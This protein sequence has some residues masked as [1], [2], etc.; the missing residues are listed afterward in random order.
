MEWPP[1]SGRSK[2]F[3][4]IDRAEWFAIETAKLKIVKGQIPILENL[5][6]LIK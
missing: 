2:E 5:E 3:P 4:E 6:K 1:K